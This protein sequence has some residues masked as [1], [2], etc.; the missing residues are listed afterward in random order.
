[1]EYLWHYYKRASSKITSKIDF[2][3]RF[4]EKIASEEKV[5]FLEKKNLSE[6]P[7]PVFLKWSR[8]QN[9]DFLEVLYFGGFIAETL[10]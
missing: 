3:L 1:M 10:L 5:F 8:I 2:D 6:D 4:V 7:E 9:G